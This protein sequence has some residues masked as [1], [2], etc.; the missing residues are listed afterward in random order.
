MTGSAPFW[1]ASVLHA[2]LDMRGVAEGLSVKLIAAAYGLTISILE[3]NFLVETVNGG[4]TS[5]VTTN[6]PAFSLR[7]SSE[8]GCS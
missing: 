4:A 3:T 6:S 1:I 8:A 2:Q 7:S 5:L